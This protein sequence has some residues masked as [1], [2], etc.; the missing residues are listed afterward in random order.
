MNENGPHRERVKG[1]ESQ[2][3]AEQMAQPAASLSRCLLSLAHI[4][5]HCF[6]KSHTRRTIEHL[7]WIRRYSIENMKL[8][9][10]KKLLKLQQLLKR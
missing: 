2:S 8:I 9:R 10:K 7:N 3:N 4:A 5:Y 1:F 6:A